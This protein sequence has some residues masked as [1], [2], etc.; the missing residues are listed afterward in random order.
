MPEKHHEAKITETAGMDTFLVGFLLF[1]MVA[2][3]STL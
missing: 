1:F 2:L 3:E